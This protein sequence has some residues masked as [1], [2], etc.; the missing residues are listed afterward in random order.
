LKK[1]DISTNLQ[2][3]WEK[4]FLSKEDIWEPICIKLEKKPLEQKRYGYPL[5]ENLRTN[6]HNKLDKWV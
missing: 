4:E 6:S 1:K 3:I 5:V 2:R